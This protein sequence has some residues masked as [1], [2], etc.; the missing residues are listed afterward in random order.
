MLGHSCKIIDLQGSVDK[1]LH[2]G[3][4]KKDAPCLIYECFSSAVAQDQSFQGAVHKEKL[5]ICA[6]LTRVLYGKELGK[7]LQTEVEKHLIL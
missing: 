7:F 4:E 6:F 5:F 1:P 2:I 3:K